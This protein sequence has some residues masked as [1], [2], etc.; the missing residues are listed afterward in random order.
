MV[1][2]KPLLKTDAST[3]EDFTEKYN[4]ENYKKLQKKVQKNIGNS[5]TCNMKMVALFLTISE[6]D[7]LN[8]LKMCN[9]KE[10]QVSEGRCDL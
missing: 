7:N 2:T 1:R 9:K 3:D 10:E 4:P 6:F 5:V 8:L